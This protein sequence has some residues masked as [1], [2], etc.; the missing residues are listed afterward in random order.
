MRPRLPSGL[1][2]FDE[3]V[4]GGIPDGFLVALVGEPGCGKTVFSLHFA[5]QGLLNNEPVIYVSTE[6]PLDSIIEQAT[7]FN[8]DFEKHLGRKLIIISEV[9]AGREWTLF[10]PDHEALMGLIDK[11]LNVLNYD[12]SVPVRIVVDSMSTFWA[13]KPAMSRQIAIEMRKYFWNVGATVYATS[14]TS[15]MTGN[16]FGWGIEYIADAI[17]R[18]RKDVRNELR[19]FMLIEKMRQTNHYKKWIEIDIVPKKGMV[20]VA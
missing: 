5:H 3:L 9:D 11:A 1:Q 8:M 4:E 2:W 14:Q 7:Q 17:L 6:E 18:F 20:R 16:A 12:G 15:S 10:K 13:N 19:R